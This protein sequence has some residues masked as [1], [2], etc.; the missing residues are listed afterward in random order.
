[1][2]VLEIAKT[3]MRIQSSSKADTPEPPTQEPIQ[4]PNEI[5]SI[6]PIDRPF[7]TF[8]DR[9]A[10]WATIDFPEHIWSHPA[11]DEYVDALAKRYSGGTVLFRS[12][13][14]PEHPVLDWYLPRQFHNSNF[15]EKFWSTPT[16]SRFFQPAD[17][18]LNYYLKADQFTIFNQDLPL[19]LAGTLASLHFS[20]GAY[21]HSRGLGAVSKQLGEAAAAELI[22]DD[23]DETQCFTSSVRWSDFS[24]MSPGISPSSS[25][26]NHK[27]SSIVY[28]RPTRTNTVG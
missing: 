14:M 8:D 17:P 13:Q 10:M 6:L 21:S 19:M 24:M 25:S 11:I 9:S 12:F 3:L 4:S 7:P 16:P 20:G 26:P 27:D 1:M 28:W 22:A 2:S 23:F 15:F 18:A 5:S